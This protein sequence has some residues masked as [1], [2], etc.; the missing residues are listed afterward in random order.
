MKKLF[1]TII[2]SLLGLPG[3]AF[4]S[5]L[6]VEAENFD[7]KGG[8]VVDQQFMDQ[9]GSPYLLAHGLGRPVADAST[10]IRFPAKGKYHVFVRTYN[11]TSPWYQGKGP[12]KFEVI[13]DGKRL[14]SPLGC[15]G[16]DWE[17]QYAGDVRIRNVDAEVRLH[18]LTGFDGRC[19]AV[20]FTTDS[21]CLL[22]AGNEELNVFRK[23]MRTVSPDARDAGTYD[24]VVVGGGIAGI[25]AAVS[26]A[27][28]GCKVALVN[29]RPVLG[30]NN[31]SEIR[32]HM[33]GQINVGPYE[34]LGNLQ[35]E[36]CPINGGNAQPAEVYEDEKKL[37]WI[38]KEDNVTLFL[39]YRAVEVETKDGRILSVTAQHVEMG[40][41][42]RLSA[43]VFSDCT[44][45]GIL[46]LLSGA[47][48][49]MGRE[50]K[51]EFG[52]ELAEDVSDKLTMGASVQWYS[53]PT[54]APDVF[55]EFNYGMTFNEQ[56]AE[57][58]LMGE[59]TWE[60]GM[61]RNQISEFEIIRDYGMLAVYS[62]WSYLKNHAEDK[63]S[64]ANRQLSW[65]AYVAGKRE[66][67][68]LLGDYVLT[69]KDLDNDVYHDD[70][71]FTTTWSIDLHE[72]DPSNEKYFPNNAFK[73]ITHHHLIYHSAVPY[74][75][76]YSRN[77]SNLFMAGR[78]ISVTHV[79]LGTVRVMRTTGMMGE[80]V[81]M[82]A[83]LCRRYKAT[84]REIY[85]SYLLE[86][87][88]LMLKGV[89]KDMENTQTYNI[90]GSLGPWPK[91]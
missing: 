19:D 86:L 3:T 44:G 53:M 81:G 57:H 42:I 80:V 29:D 34:K 46:G 11:W 47:D 5:E 39:N 45:D 78:N 67:T 25:C 13:V 38:R 9:M 79:A 37:D 55:P 88:S 48:W 32:V 64:Y 71:S 40:E 60:T 24:F 23:R 72:P 63:D 43:P 52:E 91:E 31:S 65:M 4:A 62:N 76:L 85:Q 89:G 1:C 59:W 41:Q 20:F 66:S 83:S 16:Q 51:E 75:C 17:W 14:F 56:N 49:T 12:G 69:Q 77:I 70:A 82:A 22:P 15:D 8:W 10:S 54:N 50:S 36:F 33:G 7:D 84:P 30:G 2:F 74:R 21:H 26:A 27:R 61:N 28:L 58:V 87:K 68:R 6:L 73:A 35:K 18:D 90:G